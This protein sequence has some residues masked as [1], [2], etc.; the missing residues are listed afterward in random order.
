MRLGTPGTLF[1]NTAALRLAV[2]IGSSVTSD[3]EEKVRPAA[4]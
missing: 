4:S 1:H 2:S 3:A